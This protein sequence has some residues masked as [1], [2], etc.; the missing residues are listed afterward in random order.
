[1]PLF[2]LTLAPGSNFDLTLTNPEVSGASAPI[3]TEAPLISG[4]A[5][6]G[7]VL[8]CSTGT[9]TG[10]P[11]PTYTYQWRANSV[12]ISGATSSTYTTVSGNIGQTVTC[13]VTGTNT[14][15]SSSAVSS[16]GIS[17]TAAPVG[18][19]SK[20]SYNTQ[21]NE[22]SLFDN[23]TP[24][25]FNINAGYAS[26]D[27][28]I[29][30]FVT[31]EFITPEGATF[32]VAIDGST[33]T[34]IGTQQ[35]IFNS[36]FTGA[37]AL[38][39]PTGSGAKEI[40]I[41]TASAALFGIKVITHVIRGAEWPLSASSVIAVASPGDDLSITLASSIGD[42][43][44]AAA[45]VNAGVTDSI[46][47]DSVTHTSNTAI[48]E[49]FTVDT[50][51]SELENVSGSVI[52]DTLVSTNALSLIAV[53]FTP[54][55][56]TYRNPSTIMGNAAI[57]WIDID[58]GG[59]FQ[60]TAGTTIS[61]VG[62][63][64]QYLT[65]GAGGEPYLWPGGT[66]G[67][68]TLRAGYIEHRS[69]FLRKPL[70]R[71]A[72]PISYGLEVNSVSDIT[73]TVHRPLVIGGTASEWY[74][75]TWFSF[76]Q[77]GTGTRDIMVCETDLGGVGGKQITIGQFQDFMAI[78]DSSGDSLVS[79]NGLE[80]ITGTIGA[81]PGATNFA[82]FGGAGTNFG[83]QTSDPGDYDIKRM[84]VLNAEPTAEQREQLSLWLK[85]GEN[86]PEIT[87]L[88]PQVF[89]TESA[90]TL[91]MTVDTS[92][93]SDDRI[94]VIALVGDQRWAVSSAT[95]GGVSATVV[96]SQLGTGDVDASLHIL[97][98]IVPS[99]TGNQTC[100]I[101]FTGSLF[102]II[103]GAWVVRGS[104]MPV[105]SAAAAEDN[106][107]AFQANVSVDTPDNGA[108]FGIIYLGADTVPSVT[109]GAVEMNRIRRENFYSSAFPI[110]AD[111]NSLS[112]NT[113]Q[114]FQQDTNFATLAGVVIFE[115]ATAAPP[116]VGGT[117]INY[118]SGSAWV[119]APLFRWSGTEWS[120]AT[121]QR[122]NGSAWV[123]A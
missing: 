54:A 108:A 69:A 37:Y 83:I 71:A 100:S 32:N 73:A 105:F 23:T 95:F 101:T 109:I 18:F 106:S 3:N 57:S 97:S 112:T 8:S 65:D 72:G 62:D 30:V 10:S 1:M 49:N 118:W 13:Q 102:S 110:L 107:F 26:A 47:F 48:G 103:A 52:V 56:L 104:D 9:W 117:I 28:I 74:S 7:S 5:I 76:D 46:T 29:L 90:S 88:G 58:K 80:S 77:N 6:E 36:L 27:R 35:Y 11:T 114:I 115:P 15:G 2:D 40:S 33:L 122:W 89:S 116:P 50:L 82:F 41:T 66:A 31:S 79:L 68:P 96:A 42:T 44:F 22:I 38:Q 113:S 4:S 67:Q 14:E 78:I 94:I 123:D 92:Y 51:Y 21:L 85:H 99:G 120:A 53:S 81:T 20:I 16:N 121:L 19:L 111:S 119:P 64:V 84:F 25:S 61:T 24:I 34:T 17:V 91:N 98:A 70:T 55:L 43:I 63:T 87:Y 75:G 86:I 59:M 12:D 93:P 60:D 45:T 39:I